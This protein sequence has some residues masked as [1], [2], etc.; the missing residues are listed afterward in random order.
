MAGKKATL[1][2]NALDAYPEVY[3]VVPEKSV[4]SRMNI[5]FRVIKVEPNTSRYKNEK[6]INCNRAAMSTKPRKLS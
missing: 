6:L 4:R 2:Y 1:L 5:C 3:K